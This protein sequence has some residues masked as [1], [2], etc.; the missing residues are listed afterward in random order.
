[1]DKVF[2]LPE[3]PFLLPDLDESWQSYAAFNPCVAGGNGTY[4]LL[5]RALSAPRTLH[6]VKLSVSSIGYAAGTGLA[7]FEPGRPLIRPEED[8]ERFGCE[9]PRVTEMDGTWYIF[10]TAL[11]AYPFGA[12]NI[13]VGVALTRDFRTLE[14][15]QLVTPFN[16]KAMALFP[17]KI[18]GRLA[19]V[20]TVDTDRPPAKICLAYFDSPE[21][22]WSERYWEDWHASL[23]SHVIPLL[24]SPKDHLEVGAPPVRTEAGW[25]LVYSYIRNYLGAEKHFGIEAVLLDLE[26]PS[27]VRGRT[28]HPIL[29]PETDYEQQGMVPDVIFPSGALIEDRDLYIYYGAT[30]TTGCAA[31]V[32]LDYL[33][34][35]MAPVTK[36]EFTASPSSPEGFER[37]SGNPI[38][39]PR[40]ELH[41]EARATFNPAAIHAGDRVH[42]LYR[43]MSASGTS[44]LGYASSHDG[45]T[46]D[47]RLTT[48]VY[49]PREPFEQRMREGYSGCEDPRLTRIDDRIHM[50]YTAF[51]GYTP[52][53]ALTSIDAG[54][55][56]EKKWGWDKPRVI[57]PPGKPNK[58]ACLFPERIDGRYG[59]FHRLDDV[60]CLNF[61]DSLEQL[62]EHSLGHAEHRIA[63]PRQDGKTWKYG[64]SAPPIKTPGGWLLLFHRVTS[65]GNTYVAE[66]LLL[67]GKDPTRVVAQTD[68]TLLKPEMDYEKT[69]E[70]SNVVFPCGAVLIDGDVYLYYGGGDKVVGVARMKLQSIM[71][72][73][74]EL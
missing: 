37:F 47:E 32:N 2:R 20:L 60:I 62:D 24:R 13:R 17:E 55:F 43:A 29:V 42:I 45:F 69:G 70:V 27:I 30:D 54:D 12:D 66:A 21:D 56:L 35:S 72:R 52:R 8:W 61:F 1:M 44:V 3:N 19:A 71:N 48:P 16:A 65:P 68:S 5:Y 11:S 26:A 36:N 41:W 22:I 10:Y 49:V 58:N 59:I 67:D 50:T 14:G 74:R 53:V 46:I 23:A 33:L 31:R 40:P 51:D 9:D 15:K 38:I 18:N 7:R 6:G 64:I 4:H 57:S 28:P 63:L 73:M 25:L 39:R 34:E